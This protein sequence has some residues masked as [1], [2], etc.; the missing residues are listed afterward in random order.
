VNSG[1]LGDWKLDLNDFKC[2]HPAGA[3]SIKKTAVSPA[4]E[5]YWESKIVT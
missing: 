3:E 2:L 1:A 5:I 4:K